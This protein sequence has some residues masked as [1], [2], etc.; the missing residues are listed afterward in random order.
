VPTVPR[1]TEPDVAVVPS[2]HDVVFVGGSIF[3][4][5]H[6]SI[7][8]HTTI[9]VNMGTSVYVR[10]AMMAASAV[11]TSA[12]VTSA[13]VTS[14]VAFRVRCRHESKSERRSDRKHQANLLQHFCFLTGLRKPVHC[15]CRNKIVN[16]H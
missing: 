16:A 14:A 11:V 5:A 12:V 9:D 15:Y 8:V 1:M 6:V 3:V 10:G 2:A 4:H 13:V 7:D